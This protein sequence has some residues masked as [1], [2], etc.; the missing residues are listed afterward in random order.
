MGCLDAADSDDNGKVELTD[1]IRVLNFLFT[2]GN[3][4]PEPYPEVGTDRTGD[5]LSCRE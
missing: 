1:A 4:P 2:G 3:A 5:G